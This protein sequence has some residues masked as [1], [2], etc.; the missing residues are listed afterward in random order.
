MHSMSVIHCMIVLPLNVSFHSSQGEDFIGFLAYHCWCSKPTG[1]HSHFSSATSE[2]DWNWF[3]TSSHRW[4]S[5][6]S[7]Q[8][9]ALSPPGLVQRLIL[10]VYNT[11][12]VLSRSLNGRGALNSMTATDTSPIRQY[13][14]QERHFVQYSATLQG[15]FPT[16]SI[17]VTPL[18]LSQL[19]DGISLL[20]QLMWMS[21]QNPFHPV[22]I[23][24]E[25]QN[26]KLTFAWWTV[27]PNPGGQESW[28]QTC[29]KWNTLGVEY[30]YLLIAEL[31][32]HS[33]AS[34][35]HQHTHVQS[36]RWMCWA[37]WSRRNWYYFDNG[38]PWYPLASEPLLHHGWSSFVP[39]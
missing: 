19:A 24:L 14:S 18:H 8:L 37:Q 11:V 12:V 38:F 34:L 7:L 28:L 30:C 25:Y 3:H 21:F 15:Y 20:L 22:T 6:S 16:K 10:A 39:Q 32:G 13:E 2:W 4:H 27:W 31:D 23:L 35:L 1:W 17:A 26:P 5:W 33:A 36:C 9:W 29:M